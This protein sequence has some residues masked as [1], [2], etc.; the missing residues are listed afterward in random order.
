MV[1][2]DDEF[3]R[4]PSRG[5]ERNLIQILHDDVIV[6]GSEILLVVSLRDEW[7][8]VS[9]PNSMNVDTIEGNVRRSIAPSATQQI[10]VV[11]TSHDSA[12]DFPEMKLGTPRLR[13]GVI[14]PVED[15]Y[16]H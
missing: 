11:P 14:L 9:R 2:Q 7:I 13:I 12:E 10:D 1:Y 3:A 6:V 16:A 5:I 15:E 8:G 4:L